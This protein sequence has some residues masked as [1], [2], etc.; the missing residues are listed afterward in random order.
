M[1][2]SHVFTQYTVSVSLR[3]IRKLTWCRWW[4]RR[5]WWTIH[6]WCCAL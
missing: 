1:I 3:T 2:L 4:L 5:F 6:C